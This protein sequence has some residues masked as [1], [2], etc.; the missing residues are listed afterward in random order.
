MVAVVNPPSPPVPPVLGLAW[1]RTIGTA[2]RIFACY[3]VG[4]AASLLS[5][6]LLAPY[7][8]LVAPAAPPSGGGPP[9]VTAYIEIV[10]TAADIDCIADLRVWV[11]D[12][13]GAAFLWNH[14]C[15][16]KGLMSRSEPTWAK[17]WEKARYLDCYNAAVSSSP[18]ADATEGDMQGQ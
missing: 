5:S 16:G 7:R 15:F 3:I 1:A 9:P 17:R 2:L 13:A 8:R 11:T 10:P 4:P 12:P 14:G 6:L 18:R